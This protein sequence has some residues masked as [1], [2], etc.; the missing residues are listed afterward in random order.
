MFA[1]TVGLVGL[2][3]AWRQKSSR[4]AAK[5]ALLGTSSFL[6]LYL[7]TVAPLILS[8]PWDGTHYLEEHYAISRRLRTQADYWQHDAV[9]TL[10]NL[11]VGSSAHGG[12]DFGLKL[13]WGATVAMVLCCFGPWW[14][15]RGW[16]AVP[17]LCSGFIVALGLA[18]WLDRTTYIS[19]HGL[20]LVVLYIAFVGWSFHPLRTHPESLWGLLAVNGLISVLAG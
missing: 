16:A 6:A 1:G 9:R 4:S 17:L 20:I 19:I 14:V 11:V 3:W 12:V 7:V 13:K 2:F 8:G 18:A 15:R 5:K 10:P